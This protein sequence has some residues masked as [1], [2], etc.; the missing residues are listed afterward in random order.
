MPR[1]L[2]ARPTVQSVT[3]PGRGQIDAFH[4]ISLGRFRLHL[5]PSRE[6]AQEIMRQYLRESA[7]VKE[8]AK[9]WWR[10]VEQKALNVEWPLEEIRLDAKNGMDQKSLKTE[11]RRKAGSQQRAL[12]VDDSVLDLKEL[13]EYSVTF[14]DLDPIQPKNLRQKVDERFNKER[15]QADCLGALELTEEERLFTRDDYKGWY[16]KVGLRFKAS[17][18][19]EVRR[20]LSAK[21]LLRISPK[22][23]APDRQTVL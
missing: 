10:L 21:A 19:E 11:L 9:R 15:N 12:E 4:F 14:K 17:E 2:Y 18:I 23:K 5:D 16:H 22:P 8:Y 6:M 13:V 7:N 20:R 1:L 3:H